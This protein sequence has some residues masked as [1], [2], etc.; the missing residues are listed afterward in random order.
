M[1]R[2]LKLKWFV[3]QCRLC[4]LWLSLTGSLLGMKLADAIELYRSDDEFIRLHIL[5]SYSLRDL[6]L[7]QFWT[8]FGG[9]WLITFDPPS[10]VHG[11]IVLCRAQIYSMTKCIVAAAVMQLLEEHCSLWVRPD[12]LWRFEDFPGILEFVWW[13]LCDRE[14][15]KNKKINMLHL[16][17]IILYPSGVRLD[18]W[19]WTMS[20][21]N[22]CLAFRISRWPGKCVSTSKGYALRAL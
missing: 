1:S 17:N 8:R 6:A 19:I 16:Q 15:W 4:H 22:T 10:S 2:V 12:F 14:I 5:F 21:P 20:W 13:I 3:W 11:Y 9:T 18:T 7:G